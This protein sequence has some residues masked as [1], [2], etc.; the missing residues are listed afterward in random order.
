MALRIGS[1][2][3]NIQK[4][5]LLHFPIILPTINKQKSIISVLTAIDTQIACEVSLT[6]YYA[7]QKDFLLRDLFI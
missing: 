2:L 5:D 7:M 4:K 1:G 3:P 6:E